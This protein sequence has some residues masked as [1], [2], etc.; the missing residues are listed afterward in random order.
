MMPRPHSPGAGFWAAIGPRLKPPA[1]FAHFRAKC[2]V[3][4][5]ID[6]GF[7]E[8][9]GHPEL[10]LTQNLVELFVAGAVLEIGGDGL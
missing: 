10:D 5:S 7:C 4:A 1:R 9:H 6:A 8:F 3:A 2:L